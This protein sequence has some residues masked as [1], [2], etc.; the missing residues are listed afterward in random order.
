MA[1]TGED[2]RVSRIGCLELQVA[3]SLPESLNSEL[4]IYNG[5]H[6][7]P[8]RRFDS[9]VYEHHITIV[10]TS[11]THG[12]PT[13]AHHERGLWVL[14]ELFVEVNALNTMVLCG[15]RKAGLD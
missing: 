11:F 5:D 6:D 15:R 9:T 2:V 14:D 13:H 10:D 3:A 12:C 8:M 1:V 4:A 7:M